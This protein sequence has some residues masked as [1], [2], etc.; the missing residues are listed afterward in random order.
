MKRLT[1]EEFIT[2]ARAIH[3][4]KYDYSK[5]EYKNSITK[6]TVICPIHGEF[7]VI[8]N[9]HIHKKCGCTKCSNTYKSNTEEFIAKAREI[10]GNKYDYSKVE[11]VNNKT[12]VC[13]I[14]KEKNILGETHGEFW[15]RPNDHLT[16]Y[17]CPKCGNNNVPTTEEFI[18]KARAIHGDKYDYSKVEY[19]TSHEKIIIICPIHGEFK[20]I[21]NNHLNGNACPHCNSDNK[22]KMEENIHLMLEEKGIKHVRQKTF[23]WLKLQR[24]LFLD[25]YLPYYKIAIEVQGEQHFIPTKR[26]G[27]IEFFLKQQERDKAKKELCEEH[28]IKIIYITRKNYS[29]EEVLN[30]IKKH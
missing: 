27:G 12:K 13:I 28:N 7:K 20:Q 1:T 2:K 30:E 9:D 16:E 4:N 25:F 3:G 21:P 11:Y 23:P 15:Q 29:I 6:I 18:A 26:F 14:C 10:H 5:V 24:N 19:T 17:A 8:P 22:S